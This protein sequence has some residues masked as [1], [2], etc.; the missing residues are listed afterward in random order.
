MLEFRKIELS[1]RE[2]IKELL[3]YSDFRTCEYS[4]GNNFCWRDVFN[5]KI[6]RYR[7]FYIVE[8][9]G[10]LFYPAG[11]GDVP[12]LIDVLKEH[13]NESGKP[14]YFSVATK[15]TMEMLKELYAGE[16]EI[17]VNEDFS[18]Y[19]YD[20]NDLSTLAGKKYHSK[21]N[22]INRIKEYNWS[23]EPLSDKNINECLEMDKLWTAENAENFD[24]SQQQEMIATEE[25]L[26]HYAELEYTGGLIRIDEKVVAYSFGEKLNSDTFNTHVEKALTSINGTYPL[27]NFELANHIAKDF[28]YINREEDLG[29]ENLRKAKKSY[30]PCFMEE[31]YEIRFI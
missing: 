1:D 29:E 24:I 2:W 13:C 9:E 22:Y 15:K 19:I 10:E 3:S 12:E 18:D 14:L 5:I 30:Y 8:S 21:R 11:R 27:I 6:A 17:R 31:K 7:D 20:V 26:T 28:K 16:L 4:F 25:G 23:F